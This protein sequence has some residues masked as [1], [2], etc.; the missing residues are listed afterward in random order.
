VDNINNRGQ[1]IN[2]QVHAV[3]M[4]CHLSAIVYLVPMALIVRWSVDQPTAEVALKLV[5]AMVFFWFTPYY[6]GVQEKN[7]HPFI[8]QQLIEIRRYQNDSFI[9]LLPTAIFIITW[10]NKTSIFHAIYP[11]PGFNVVGIVF[12]GLLLG[13]FLL[14]T[15][16]VSAMLLICH[17]LP[18]IRGASEA[19]MGKSYQYPNI[20]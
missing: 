13:A 11:N 17:F 20:F 2:S 6:F 18:V 15:G 4:L 9:I 7:L 19:I 5:M 1:K 12:V 14:I 3:G 16:I 8:N 10:L